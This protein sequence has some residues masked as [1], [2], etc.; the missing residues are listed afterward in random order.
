M[1]NRLAEFAALKRSA[2]RTVT[3]HVVE[4]VVWIMKE[5]SCFSAC[6]CGCP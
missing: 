3:K 6:L 2:K 5:G 4:Y 1:K